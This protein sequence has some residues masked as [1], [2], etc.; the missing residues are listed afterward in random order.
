VGP[1][2]EYMIKK[3]RII[4]MFQH[5]ATYVIR[6]KAN[7]F[8]HGIWSYWSCRNKKIWSKIAL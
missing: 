7:F 4:T 5:R 6:T 3:T 2:I 8:W 1:G